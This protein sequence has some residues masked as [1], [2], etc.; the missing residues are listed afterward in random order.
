MAF[1]G[2]LSSMS[3]FGQSLYGSGIS[4]DS[5]LVRV[6]F[7]GQSE[8]PVV[9]K[10]GNE[11]FSSAEK[12]LARQYHPVSPGMYFIEAGSQWIEII[13]AGSHYYTIIVKDDT[14]L[15]FEDVEHKA[16]AKSQVY[17]YNILNDEKATLHVSGG[18][19]ALFQDMDPAD[20]G[21]IAINPVT[22]GFAL[23]TDRGRTEELGRLPLERGGSTT[24]IIWE[25]NSRLRSVVFQ[26][27]VDKGR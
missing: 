4:P 24:V 22:V 6:V 5:A 2:L 21:Q 18:T 10:I 16:P 19:E 23:K 14:C 20:S 15:V 26:A 7:M 25:E 9:I 8:K 12:E 27:S 11:T 13:T 1:L 3:V 17:F